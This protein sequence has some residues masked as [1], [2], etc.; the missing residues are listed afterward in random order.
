MKHKEFRTVEAITKLN[1]AIQ[2]INETKLIL[3]VQYKDRQHLGKL[4][5][6]L[7]DVVDHLNNQV[8]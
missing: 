3:A 5:G 6:D 8:D 2:L 4:S 7:G 1:M